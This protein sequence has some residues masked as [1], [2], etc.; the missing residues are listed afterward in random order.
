M[1]TLTRGRHV[2]NCRV[3]QYSAI[4]YT[5]NMHMEW[6][7]VT[8]N[9]PVTSNLK[10]FAKMCCAC[11][12]IPKLA[13]RTSVTTSHVSCAACD[14]IVVWRDVWLSEKKVVK[15]LFASDSQNS[16]NAD[17]LLG[18]CSGQ[19]TGGVATWRDQS[20]VDDSHRGLHTPDSTNNECL[21]DVLSGRF[22]STQASQEDHDAFRSA[23]NCNRTADVDND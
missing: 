16:D 1:M 8:G 3:G 15:S 22:T 19:F 13:L 6:K 14:K 9:P 12:T 10:E 18:L 23:S 11:N 20:T 4:L 7:I 5:Q 2:P 21:L 17:E